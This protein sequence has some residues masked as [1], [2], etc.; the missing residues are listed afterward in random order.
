MTLPN[1]LIIG[2][3][4]AGTSSLHYYLRQHPQIFMPFLKEP[5]FFA[6]ENEELNFRNPDQGINKYSITKLEDYQSLFEGVT[7]EIAI[8]EA[9][10]IYL[11][12][13]KAAERIKHYIP[14][15]KL[16]VVLR[17]PV[18]RAFSC[19]T[20]LLREGYEKLPFL[21]A[22][23]EENNRIKD[24]WAH[25]WH[26]K[27]AGYYYQQ[28]KPYVDNFRT[29]QLRV[30]LYDDFVNNPQG[31]LREVFN[32]LC[33]DE[34]FKPDMTRMNVSGL[35]KSRILHDFF[36]KKNIVRSGIQALFPGNFR[37]H[38][39]GKIK[40]WNLGAKPGISFEDRK[41]LLEDF[42]EDVQRLQVLI[43]KDLSSWL[44]S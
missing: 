44:I 24:N 34:N 6:L 32:F 7:D 38:L 37:T 23:S 4:K 33:V 5:M 2:A 17:N 15:A 30:F 40:S 39:A 11:Y 27:T 13:K 8:G 43:D 9:S 31:F 18:D 25:L 42:S 14:E 36:A 20:H 22:L 16:I 21:E 1:F 3:A 29:E 28:L 26:Y 19:Y 12:S 41:V 10:P 35:P